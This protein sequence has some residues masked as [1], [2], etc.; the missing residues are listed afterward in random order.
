MKWT[1]ALL[2]FASPS[3]AIEGH[4]APTAASITPGSLGSSVIA[5]SITLGAM[6]GSPTLDGTNITGVPDASLTANVGL[7]NRANQTFT[8]VNTFTS[9]MTVN[10]G[11]ATAPFW[12][13]TSTTGGTGLCVAS[14]GTVGVG[15]CDANGALHIY[16]N[17]A[18]N[19]AFW[20]GTN[21]GTQGQIRMGNVSNDGSGN[22]DIQ[23]YAG[24]TVGGIDIILQRS[25][26]KVAI[27]ANT[28][29]ETLHNFGTFHQAGA[30]TFASS[31]T[32]NAQTLVTPGAGVA[33]TSPVLDITSQTAT[34]KLLTVLANGNVGIG[35]APPSNR[36]LFI[37]GPSPSITLESSFSGE[38]FSIVK[39]QFAGGGVSFQDNNG[40]TD[41]VTFL[42]SGSVGIGDTTPASMLTVGDGD[43]FQ[44]GST[45]N[46]STSGTLQVSGTATL[47]SSV[48][49]N[50]AMLVNGAVTPYLRTSAQIL[51]I[52][53]VA[54]GEVYSCSNCAVPYTLCVSTGTAVADMS[55]IYSAAK[56]Q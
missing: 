2:L 44:V 6:Y 42:N 9:S 46:V 25:G 55:L 36:T 35:S 27:G 47:T 33:P 8:G 21:A 50:A 28:P 10:T 49:V 19:N 37:Q 53:P 1:I 30:S 29:T 23:T 7:L 5:S 12:A 24:N 18:E 34:T 51:A 17:T 41:L 15:I 16:A 45:G 3:L 26:G 56:C 13:S 31:V 38:D 40:A 4:E 54:A 11:A 20:L 43:D 22:M 14:D 32:V 52:D 48:T 39:S